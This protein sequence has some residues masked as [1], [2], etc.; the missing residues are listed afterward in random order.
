VNPSLSAI[1]SQS[2]TKFNLAPKELRIW[3]G[4]WR[5]V[6]PDQA[7][8]SQSTYPGYMYVEIQKAGGLVWKEKVSE[9][10]GLI[11]GFSVNSTNVHE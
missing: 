6:T 8:D 10:A 11:T 2:V 4:W 7:S 5:G 3:K 1:L 9:V